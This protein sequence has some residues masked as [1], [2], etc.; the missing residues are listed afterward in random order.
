MIHSISSFLHKWAATIFFV[1]FMAT[2][3]ATIVNISDYKS[4][5]GLASCETR[6]SGRDDLRVVLFEIINNVDT[7]DQRTYLLDFM[8]ENYPSLNCRE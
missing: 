6:K 1:G 8:E 4:E 5:V 7:E 2:Q 3:V